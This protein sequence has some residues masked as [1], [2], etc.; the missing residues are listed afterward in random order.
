LALP[1]ANS[2]PMEKPEI[3]NLLLSMIS[4]N[5]S[6]TP[7]P[8]LPDFRW[9]HRS[10]ATQSP[11]PA[12]GESVAAAGAA[13]EDLEVV[14]DQFAATAGEDGRQAGE[15]RPVLLV[16]AGRD[17]SHT[18]VVRGHGWADQCAGGGDRVAEVRLHHVETRIDKGVGGHR[19][20]ISMYSKRK[21]RL[22]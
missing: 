12:P 8:G 11:P 13:E 4:A 7:R 22:I 16:A 21:S 9:C 5:I 6:P 3:G 20:V 1:R 2:A 18:A 15:A 14:A 17:T 19:E 10:S